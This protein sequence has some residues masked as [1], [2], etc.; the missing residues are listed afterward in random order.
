MSEIKCRLRVVLSL[1]RTA[2]LF[3]NTSLLPALVEVSHLFHAC[4]NGPI[5]LHTNT[6]LEPLL[7]AELAQAVAL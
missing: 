4:K 5:I 2:E 1:F 3:Q 6:S 7:T